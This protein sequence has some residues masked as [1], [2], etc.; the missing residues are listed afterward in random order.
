MSEQRG[1]DPTK[2]DDAP[3]DPEAL[4]SPLSRPTVLYQDVSAARARIRVSDFRPPGASTD[5]NVRAIV[6]LPGVFSP[7]SS[8]DAVG[9]LLARSFR[10]VSVDLP[11]F[12]ESEKPLPTRFPYD[13]A[14]LSSSVIEVFGALGISRGHLL[15]H[16][17]GGAIALRIAAHRTELV[18]RVALL[19]PQA[20]PDSATGALGLLSSSWFGG[21]AVRQLLGRATFRRLYLN[22]INEHAP[23][24]TI[25]SHY[26]ALSTPASRA[27]L[28]ATLRGTRDTRPVIADMRRL[29]QPTLLVWGRGDRLQP[30]SQGRALSRELNGAGL[31]IVEAGHAPHEERPEELAVI[32]ERFFSGRRAGTG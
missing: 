13:L 12:G 22:Y 8:F 25:H 11:G 16:A 1:A 19:A 20:H 5:A 28:L 3:A 15:G 10:F 23:S 17:L 4:S 26:E 27:A 14:A 31:H 7:R 9:L 18:E 24:A 21:L 30:L 32:L 29:R 2:G 6:A